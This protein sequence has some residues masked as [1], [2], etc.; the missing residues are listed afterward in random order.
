MACAVS[1]ESS[2]LLCRIL[3]KANPG[4]D[5]CFRFPGADPPQRT[6]TYRPFYANLGMAAINGSYFSIPP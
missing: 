6:G 5:E 1:V 3:L 2:K 4:I